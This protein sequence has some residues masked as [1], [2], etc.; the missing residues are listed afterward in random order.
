MSTVSF[1]KFTFAF[2]CLRMK[3]VC[4]NFCK[5]CISNSDKIIF[6]QNWFQIKSDSTL[7]YKS[8]VKISSGKIELFQLFHEGEYFY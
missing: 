6:K 4:F 7:L 5:N 8:S 3:V 2:N 1:G